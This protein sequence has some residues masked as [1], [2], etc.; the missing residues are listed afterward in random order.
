MAMGAWSGL[1]AGG[2]VCEEGREGKEGGGGS[3]EPG[4]AGP[5]PRGQSGRPVYS[6]S[7]APCPC[8]PTETT[9]ASRQRPERVVQDSCRQESPPRSLSILPSSWLS[10]A[11]A[12]SQVRLLSLAVCCAPR[13]G[14]SAFILVCGERQLKAVG[15]A[16]PRVLVREH[17]SGQDGQASYARISV[18]Q[19]NV[20]EEA[21]VLALIALPCTGDTE[22]TWIEAPLPLITCPPIPTLPDLRSELLHVIRGSSVGRRARGDEGSEEGHEVER[23]RDSG[24]ATAAA[25]RARERL[26]TRRRR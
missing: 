10:C 25:V 1:G 15:R 16:M 7:L 6:R 11:R 21:P 8:R 19:P 14:A 24:Q 17:P 2:V 18:V 9:P 20:Q 26:V 23:S 4:T 12:V 5:R 3:T 13:S 22:P